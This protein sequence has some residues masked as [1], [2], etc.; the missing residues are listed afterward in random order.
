[1]VSIAMVS[2]ARARLW[3][4]LLRLLLLLLAAAAAAAAAVVVVV[5][6]HVIVLSGGATLSRAKTARSSASTRR[7]C[8]L[9]TARPTGVRRRRLV[10]R[11][12][13]G[14][15]SSA[16][17]SACSVMGTPPAPSTAACSK[18]RPRSSRSRLSSRSTSGGVSPG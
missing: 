11:S 10:S 2:I 6:G 3:V 18:V 4:G 17:A 5:G 9:M 12:A 8:L 14:A 13:S 7:S 16:R 1:M 15:M